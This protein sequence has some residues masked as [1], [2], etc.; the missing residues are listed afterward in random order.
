MNGHVF[1]VYSEKPGP[2]QFT[3]TMEALRHYANKEMRF[4]MD[5]APLFEDLKT[6]TVEMPDNITKA[7][8]D[9]L[10]KATL[11]KAK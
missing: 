3:K 11:W 2:K 4:Q 5:L 7:E 10:Q 8:S 6:P 1:Q 9:D